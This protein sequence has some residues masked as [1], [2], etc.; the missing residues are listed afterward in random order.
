MEYLDIDRNGLVKAIQHGVNPQPKGDQAMGKETENVFKL[1]LTEQEL[2]TVFNSLVERPF[3]E[4]AALVGKLQ[5]VY[6]ARMDKAE[7]VGDE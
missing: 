4:V 2:Q 3:R 5:D 7:N 1:D 6:R